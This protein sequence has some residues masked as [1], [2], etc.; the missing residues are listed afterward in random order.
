[1][2]HARS[3]PSIDQSLVTNRAVTIPASFSAIS[4]RMSRDS[5]IRAC[6]IHYFYRLP[7]KTH[8]FGEYS[9]WRSEKRWSNFKFLCFKTHCVTR[10]AL[11]CCPGT[12]QEILKEKRPCLSIIE[13]SSLLTM[14]DLCRTLPPTSTDYQLGTYLPGTPSFV[15][16]S[17]NNNT[18]VSVSPGR[19]VS[20]RIFPEVLTNIPYHL[21]T[22]RDVSAE[23]LLTFRVPR[24]L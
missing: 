18:H 4:W 13:C 22:I 5:H 6:Y 10:G 8:A 3:C 11:S 14:K 19:V 20:Q 12:S 2:R 16:C 1:M 21:H 24:F 9:C 23:A 15:R 17:L 7:P